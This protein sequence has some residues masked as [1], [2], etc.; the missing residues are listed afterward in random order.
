MAAVLLLFINKITSPRVLSGIEL[1]VN[2]VHLFKQPQ[3]LAPFSLVG[4]D[5]TVF[6][7]PACRGVGLGGTGFT[8]CP[9][10]CPTTLLATLR[11]N[12]MKSCAQVP[13]TVTGNYVNRTPGRDA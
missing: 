6:N 13:R 7:S 1:K 5:Q 2:G 4:H 9:D 10:I 12:E 11:D 8:H 3:V